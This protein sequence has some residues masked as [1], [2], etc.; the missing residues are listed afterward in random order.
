MTNQPSKRLRI[1]AGPNGSGKSTIIRSIPDRIPLGFYINA[2]DIE[3]ELREN[4][5]LDFSKFDIHVETSELRSFILK[6]GMTIQ[7]LNDKDFHLRF[8]VEGNK[9]SV[10]DTPLNSYIAADLAEF[11]RQKLLETHASF[12]FE[13]VLSHPSKLEFIKKAKQNGYRIYLYFVATDSPEININRVAIRVA[14]HGHHVDE[15]LI[16]ERYKRSLD[17]LFETVKFT[18]RAYLFDNSGKYY[19]LV[20]EIT[21]GKKVEMLDYDK[22]IPQWFIE[23]FYLKISTIG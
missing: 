23:Y 4:S 14:K 9:I 5:F 12:S 3:K 20:A 21:D 16:R 8:L 1:F 10:G 13:T 18:D 17:L 19:E 11:I 6:Y 7:K 2:D 22:Q 15:Q